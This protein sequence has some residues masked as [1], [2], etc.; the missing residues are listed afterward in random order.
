MLTYRVPQRK[1]QVVV[2]LRQGDPLLGKLFVAP[3][4]P[5]GA[6]VRLSDRLAEPGDR[7]LALVQADGTRLISRDWILRV[8]LLTE[9][10]VDAEKE[11]GAGE[12]VLV[13]CRLAD[14]SLLEGTISFAMPPGR[15][16]LID[17][18]NSQPDG[19]VPLRAGKTLSLVHLRQVVEWAAR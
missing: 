11:P 4:G 16:R 12:P 2:H 18:L 15:E 9:E 1:I 3:E 8:E 13:T 17:Y 7:F 19:F 10:D 14:G 5:G 6:V